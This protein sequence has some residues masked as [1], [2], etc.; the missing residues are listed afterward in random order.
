MPNAPSPLSPPFSAAAAA[1]AA[2][3]TGNR[4]K[5]GGG[6]ERERRCFGLKE[7]PTMELTSLWSEDLGLRG[8]RQANLF[9]Y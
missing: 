5:R 8:R 9:T 4:E 1:A 2:V 6:R 3:A 7:D